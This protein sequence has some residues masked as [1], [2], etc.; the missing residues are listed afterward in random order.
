[1]VT[2]LL[3][4]IGIRM[5]AC[6]ARSF[7]LKFLGFCNNHYYVYG[8]TKSY[9]SV[10]ETFSCELRIYR[11]VAAYVYRVCCMRYSLILT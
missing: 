2:I 1:M 5:K 6:C 4:K 3:H 9:F 8:V 11:V 10:P 7:G